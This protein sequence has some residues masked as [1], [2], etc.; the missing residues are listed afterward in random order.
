MVSSDEHFLVQAYVR[1]GHYIYYKAALIIDWIGKD[2]VSNGGSIPVEIG[3]TLNCTELVAL[4]LSD[5]NVPGVLFALLGLPFARIA[6]HP[7]RDE[8]ASTITGQQRRHCQ[9]RETFTNVH[10]LD[11]QVAGHNKRT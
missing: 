8:D 1:I 5:D 3:Q 4:G 9:K 2:E 7:H 6:V 10:D 11:P